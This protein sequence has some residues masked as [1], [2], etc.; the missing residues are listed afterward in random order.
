MR[1]KCT[2]MAWA[3]RFADARKKGQKDDKKVILGLLVAGQGM[4]C[5]IGYS[6]FG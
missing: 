3:D 4:C 1:L 2:L 6:A 5:G